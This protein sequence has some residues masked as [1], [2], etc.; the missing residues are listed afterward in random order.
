MRH[1]QLICRKCAAANPVVYLAPV[2]I[3]GA[4]TCI[5]LPCARKNG[6]LDRDGNL[7][8]GIEL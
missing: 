4:G 3:E 2:T 7:K 8:E 6:W 5:C 1:P